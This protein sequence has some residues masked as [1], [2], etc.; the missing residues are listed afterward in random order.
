MFSK[1]T[2][3]VFNS[4]NLLGKGTVA[5]GDVV[6]HGDFRLD[7]KLEGNLKVSGRLVLGAECSVKGNIESETADI[8][9]EVI[10]NIKIHQS[11][12]LKNGCR[13]EGD[14]ECSKLVMES[15]SQFNGNCRMGAKLKNLKEILGSAENVHEAAR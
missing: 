14:I 6:V 4:V 5:S 7:G 13:V 11:L 9:G 3:K 12:H 2:K 1:G 8:A 10:G 15:G